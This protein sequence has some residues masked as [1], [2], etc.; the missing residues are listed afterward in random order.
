[1]A[2]VVTNREIV[3]EVDL[4][5]ALE[6]EITTVRADVA[7]DLDQDQDLAAQEAT[8]LAMEEDT[9]R[10]ATLRKERREREEAAA[11]DLLMAVSAQEATQAAIAEETLAHPLV[12]RALAMIEDLNLL[13][14]LKLMGSLQIKTRALLRSQLPIKLTLKNKLTEAYVIFTLIKALDVKHPEQRFISDQR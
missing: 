1:M 14:K 4:A 6:T 5:L 2:D 9:T 10:E 7:E 12:P 13:E 11:A 3:L 8:P